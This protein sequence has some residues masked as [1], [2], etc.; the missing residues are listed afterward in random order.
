MFSALLTPIAFIF[1]LGLIVTVHEYGHFQVA[2]WCGVKV[3]KFSIGFGKPL[4]SKTAGQD[5]TEFVLAAIPM[6]GYVKLLSEAEL[7]HT[8]DY[9]NHDMVRSLEQAALWKRIAIVLAGSTA[10]ILLAIL[11]Y[12]GLLMTGVVGIKPII[13]VVLEKSPAAMANLAQ[14]E[15]IKKINDSP[16]SSWQEARWLL[17]NAS[18]KNK[19]INI[20]SMNEI[21]EIH[22]RRLDLSNINQDD[23]NIDQDILVKVG[24]TPFQPSVL[25]LIGEVLNNGVAEKAGLKTD[26]LVKTVNGETLVL[27]EDF[28]KVVRSSP[29][30]TLSLIINR[31]GIELPIMVT[32][33]AIEEQGQI[34]GRIDASFKID[35]STLDTYFVKTQYSLVGGLIAA[36]FKTWDTAIFSLK[37]LGNM[38]T[39]QISIKSISGPITI[40]NYAGQS[41]NLGMKVFIGFIALISISIG[42]LNLLPI[43]VLDGGHFMYYMVEFLTGK[44]VSEQVVLYGQ[45]IGF[46]LLAM[47]MVLA[48]YNDILRLISG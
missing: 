39:G 41:A 14:G 24:I 48:V 47:M 2:K 45:K 34:V 40:A 16:V 3:L 19:P 6:G 26:D 31:Q 21:Q 4:F 27:W 7:M 22:M 33:K 9:A 43:P 42:V 32:P 23:K 20:E 1:T 36:S 13:G 30:K 17:L 44:P 5:C 28:V 8:T 11:L 12:W 37:M 46:L 25:P 18:L 10:N 29:N 38:L 35:Q 15:T